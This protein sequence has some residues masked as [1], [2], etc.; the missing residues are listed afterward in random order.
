MSHSLDCQFS[1]MQSMALFKS[2]SKVTKNFHQSNRYF[3][4]VFFERFQKLHSDQKQ[5]GVNKEDE[6]YVDPEE[7]NL[8]EKI[9]G[10][11]TGEVVSNK[12][13]KSIVV[14]VD[15]YKLNRKLGVRQRKTKKFMAH[16]EEDSCEIGDVVRIRP[17]RP[18]SKRKAFTLHEI[19]KKV[20]KL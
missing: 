10:A 15:R 2:F 14:K 11:L 6:F 5:L 20:Q 12:M 17:S 18:L 4:P 8:K 9:R 3:I 7:I 13:Q 19:L 16:D 1:F